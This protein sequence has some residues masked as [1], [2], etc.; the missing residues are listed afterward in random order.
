MNV[1][2]VQ[3]FRSSLAAVSRVIV[4]LSS[5]LDISGPRKLWISETCSNTSLRPSTS[6]P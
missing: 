1:A 4:I 5:V 3:P 6:S 2:V